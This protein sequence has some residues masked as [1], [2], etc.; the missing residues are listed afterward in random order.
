MCLGGACSAFRALAEVFA[1]GDA[2]VG[3]VSK[4]FVWG[5]DHDGF[6]RGVREGE[7]LD[8]DGFRDSS[9]FVMGLE[10]AVN[11]GG[12]GDGKEAFVEFLEAFFRDFFQGASGA[13][14]I[15]IDGAVERG[16]EVDGMGGLFEFSEGLLHNIFVV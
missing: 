11:L 3:Q 6:I 13:N 1:F 10:H 5:D 2:G 14:V 7:D 8:H 16:S 15:P 4:P 9:G 12:A